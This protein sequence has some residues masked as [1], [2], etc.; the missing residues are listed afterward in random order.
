MT[1]G[2]QRK[3]GS[4]S[5]A[6]KRDNSQPSPLLEAAQER[7]KAAKDWSNVLEELKPLK[8]VDKKV[9]DDLLLFFFFSFSFEGTDSCFSVHKDTVKELSAL[10]G[11]MIV[12]LGTTLANPG[13]S[14]LRVSVGSLFKKTSKR[15]GKHKW[16]KVALTLVL[17]SRFVAVAS[18]LRMSEMQDWMEKLRG[19]S[20]QLSE[21][22]VKAPDALLQ[23]AQ[24][25]V[26][27]IEESL[28]K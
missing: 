25:R 20:T 7:A 10:H 21:S 26:A 8:I 1:E 12:P 6:K 16:S 28:W 9:S 23:Y 3:S 18:A 13:A 17:L 4:G 5:S 24:T 27:E 15:I 2:S 22:Q 11:R 19:I 14:E